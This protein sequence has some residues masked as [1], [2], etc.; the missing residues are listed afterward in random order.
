MV[1]GLPQDTNNNYHP[2]DEALRDF[3]LVATDPGSLAGSSL[4]APGPQN[5]FSALDRNGWL[6]PGLIAPDTSATAAPNRVRNTSLYTDSLSNTG[7]YPLGTL[8]IRRSYTNNT[9][10]DVTSLRFRISDITTLPSPVGVADLRAMSS[11]G[12]TGVANGRGMLVDVVGTQL[13]NSSL[14]TQ[15]GGYNA[16]LSADTITLDTPLKNGETINVEWLLG[17]KQIG[18]FRFYVNIEGLP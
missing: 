1:T 10:S 3:Q 9:G 5:L 18:S 17:V 13:E 11:P 6:T 15:G 4:G 16:T 2:T 7:F 12:A 8:A 14:Q